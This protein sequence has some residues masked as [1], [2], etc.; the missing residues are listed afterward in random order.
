MEKKWILKDLLITDESDLD[1]I[2]NVLVQNNIRESDFFIFSDGKNCL[3]EIRKN[4]ID[5]GNELIKSICVWI[6]NEIKARRLVYCEE[7][8]PIEFINYVRS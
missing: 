6:L 2:K 1:K 5:Y 8:L 4:K 3:I 7:G